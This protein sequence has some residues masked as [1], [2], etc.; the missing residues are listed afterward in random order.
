VFPQSITAGQVAEL[1]VMPTQAN[2]GKNV[3][4]TLQ[5]ERQ[6]LKQTETIT[7]EAIEGENTLEPEAAGMRE[8]FTDWLSINHPEL[9]I[10]NDTTW[11]GTI[12]NPRI[13]V[14][15]HYIFLSENWEM[16]VT[17]HVMI[18][19]YDWARIYL[20]H[21]YNQTA[22]TYAFEISSVQEQAQPQTIEV[23]DWI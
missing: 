3:T 12:V 13:L 14:V 16:Y 8:K 5:G 11:I 2:I 9:G 7:V 18:P 15:M 10:T 21:R 6:G 23:P 20:R 1:S 22:P 4:I 19:P 17:W